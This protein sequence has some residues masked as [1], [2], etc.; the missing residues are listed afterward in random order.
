M[1]L[2][3]S[4]LLAPVRIS[5]KDVHWPIIGARLSHTLNHHQNAQHHPWFYR[6]NKIYSRAPLK[7]FIISLDGMDFGLRIRRFIE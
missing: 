4:P 2:S 5:V 3:R 6:E 1:V 7:Q